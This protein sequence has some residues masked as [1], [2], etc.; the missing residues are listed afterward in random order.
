MTVSMPSANSPGSSVSKKTK[1]P[2]LVPA[3]I[4]PAAVTIGAFGAV[5]VI[6]QIVNMAMS[7]RLNAVGITPRSVGGLWGVLDAP[8]LHGSWGHL[9][10]NLVPLLVFGFLILV[11]GLRQFVAVTVLVWLIAGFGVWLTGPSNSVTVG[12]SVLVFGWLAFLVLRGF[13]GR[14][15]GQILLGLALL[16]IW[17][18]IFWGLLP[19]RMGISW[20]GHLFGALGGALAAFLVSRA[21]APRRK[22]VA[23]APT[24]PALPT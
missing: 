16:A 12:A 2:L 20:Q 3:R 15:L 19:G 5:L 13:F 23:P 4:K 24:T 6:V 17:G 7:Y 18:G 1:S 14:N 10:S 21:D 11:G 22:Q 8:L 9:L